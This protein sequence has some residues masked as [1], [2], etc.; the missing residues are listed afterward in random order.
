MKKTVIG[1]IMICA[2][3]PALADWAYR[4]PEAADDLGSAYVR[5]AQGQVLDIGCGNGGLIS[6]SLRP[7]VNVRTWSGEVAML[8]FAVDGRAA[9]RV[10][11]Q[12][13]DH[14]CSSGMMADGSPWPVGQMQALTR[15]LRSGSE[16]QIELGPTRL[17]GFTL[18]GSTAALNRLKAMTR[19]DGL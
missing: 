1:A 13:A 9:G 11:S 10:P 5:N 14:G 3:T 8:A 19:C 12:C 6:V 16:L 7:D 2:A 17:A 15:A 4:A 18:A